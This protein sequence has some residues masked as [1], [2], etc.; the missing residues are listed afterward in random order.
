MWLGKF[1]FGVLGFALGGLFGGMLGILIGHLIDKRIILAIH[2]L[3]PQKQQ[4]VEQVF[5]A[6]VFSL[7]GK[8][9][10]AD[11]RISEQEI[12]HA[13][14]LMASMGLT[15]EH[16]LEA[17]RLFKQGAQTDFSVRETIA[18][19]NAVCGNRLN[20][21]QML[22]NYLVSQA[23]A[24]KVL[25]PAEEAVLREIAELLGVPAM[26]LSRFIEMIKAQTQFRQTHGHGY[27]QRATVTDNELQTAYRALGVTPDDTNA[28]IKKAYR[29]L[30]SENHPDKLMGQ[31]VPE[32]MVKLATERSQEIQTAYDIIVKSRRAA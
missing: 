6:T 17:I 23:I 18:T 9:A 29:K 31:G 19:F 12:Q 3:N 1:I 25:A 7:L 27:Q 30:M 26:F 14:Q 5:F 10:K 13:E 4:E 20:L 28:D 16:R 21:R 15:A 32:D 11:G 8:L 24:D 22:L 2:Q